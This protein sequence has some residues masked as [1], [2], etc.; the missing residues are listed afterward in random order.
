MKAALQSLTR[1][2]CKTIPDWLTSIGDNSGNRHTEKTV[3]LETQ[4]TTKEVPRDREGT[5][6]PGMPP[7][8]YGCK[9]H[10]L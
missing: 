2:V 4:S 1:L 9:I 8:P 7:A 3:L 5:F 6:E 10:L